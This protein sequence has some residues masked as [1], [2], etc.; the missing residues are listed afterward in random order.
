M[1]AQQRDPAQVGAEACRLLVQ[2]GGFALAWLGFCE[3]DGSVRVAAYFGERETYAHDIETRWDD[4]PLG[5]GPTGTAIREK[6]LVVTP[7]V[8]ALSTFSPWM[9]RA[10][11]HGVA[12]SLVIPLRGASTVLGALNLY[13][14]EVGP[15]DENLVGVLDEVAGLL[16]FALEAAEEARARREADEQL[17]AFFQSDAIGV[18][19]GD[20]HG[21]VSR[22]N[23]RF[24]A[25]IGYS[26]AELE[27]GEVRWDRI[28]PPEHLPLDAERIAEAQRRGACT[29]YEK[30]YIRKD[31][32]RVWVVVG[33]VLI[34]AAREFSVAFI[35]DIDVQKRVE[36]EL[37]ASEERYRHLFEHN[38]QPMWVYDRESL[39]ILDVNRAMIGHY[40][41]SRAELLGMTI[42][43]LRPEEALPRLREH[44]ASR[45][46][47]LVQAG[48]WEHRGKV[49]NTF[50]VELT[51]SDIELQGREARLAL[52]VDVTERERAR[53][54]LEAADEEIRRARDFY[55]QVLDSLPVPVWRRDTA[56]GLIFANRAYL[57]FSGRRLDEVIGAHYDTVLHPDDLA[58]AAERW[59]KAH[60]EHAPFRAELRFRNAQGEFRWSVSE[61]H[62]LFDAQGGYL[63]HIGMRVDIHDRKLMEQALRDSEALSRTAF[64]ASPDIM[65]MVDLETG[66]YVAVND[67]FVRVSG[68]S[69]DEVLGREGVDRDFWL[70]PEDRERVIAGVA[71]GQRVDLVETPVRTRDGRELLLAI[72]AERIVYRGR[73]CAIGA[74]R[75]VTELRRMEGERARLLA[76]IEQM[77]EVLIVTDLAGTILHVNPSFERVTGWASA[78]VVGKNPRML[79]SGRHDEAFYEGMWAALG[80]GEV[81]RGTVVNT[82]KDR[83]L[84][85]A[86]VAISP[87]R[88]AAGAITHYVGVQRDTTQEHVLQAQLLHA[89]KMEVVG[90]VAGGVAHDFN[91]ILTAILAS[92]QFLLEALPPGDARRADAEVIQESGE[93]AAALTRQLLTF[94]RREITAPRALDLNALLLNLSKMLGRLLRED[95]RLSLELCG[96]EAPIVA[97]P[98]QIEQVVMNLVVNARESIS[99]A[100]T[101]AV[102]TR[103]VPSVEE[104]SDPPHGRVRIEVED[105]G[106]GMSA[107][108]RA[109]I[110]EPFFTTKE[111]GTGLGLSTVWSIVEKIGG[112]IEL[113]SDLGRGSRFRV[114]LPLSAP[115]VELME[116]R[117]DS[118][119]PPEPTSLLVVEDDVAVRALLVRALQ[120]RGYTVVSASGAEDAR[121]KVR[122]SGARFDGVVTD[123]VLRDGSGFALAR[124][125]EAAQPGLRILLMS[126]Y[127]G[128][129]DVLQQIRHAKVT[130]LAKPFTP[131]GVL[132]AIRAL[133]GD[134]TSP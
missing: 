123:L 95:I 68:F 67:A 29:P 7:D 23:D 93:R 102:R 45:R 43:D 52:A 25:I 64:N 63:G 2:E 44:L 75:D 5:R 1:V 48:I 37:R 99:G 120:S 53:V 113:E 30:E 35:L 11:R 84:Y 65:I 107:A 18:L 78:E 15:F 89:Q 58:L 60:Q 34:G 19:F 105:N 70:R 118:L 49:G 115:S 127:S 79:K 28:T 90:R 77:A 54:A 87:V 119:A 4:T 130:F 24:L 69:R 39:A 91:N 97:D 86:D 129:A 88:D 12:A 62:P 83:S 36:H 50:L 56:A 132:A 85:H 20:V 41:Y 114:T 57:A 128:D 101:I 71:K 76:A 72:A 121:V 6:R 47:G 61:A 81:F 100:G 32:K 103:I 104:R 92:A 3:P 66:E 27:A 13:S 42:E 10:K 108:T 21:G 94:S 109:R 110:F 8:Q 82:R 33:Y 111:R 98:G 31:G 126:G 117:E 96:G 116:V 17:R 51:V 106:A 22:A 80:R 125:L 133:F 73:G 46:E 38:A 55:E 59:T 134:D 9:E 14:A 16:A 74:A 40:G 122:A 26:R 131:R 112:I 124:E